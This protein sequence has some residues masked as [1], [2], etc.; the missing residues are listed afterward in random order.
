MDKKGKPKCD[1][2]KRRI[3]TRKMVQM[4]QGNRPGKDNSLES[5]QRKRG[6]K[7]TKE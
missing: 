5:M 2:K 4:E 3:E 7:R 6:R 1:S